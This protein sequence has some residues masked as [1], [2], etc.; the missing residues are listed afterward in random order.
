MSTL[1]RRTQAG[2]L[3]TALVAGYAGAAAYTALA[4]PAVAVAGD[5]GPG[6]GL[7]RYVVTATTGDAAGLLEPLAALEGVASV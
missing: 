4:A 5:L 6:D 2:V 1:R 7:T 3:V